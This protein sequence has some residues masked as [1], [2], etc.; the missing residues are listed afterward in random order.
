MI[1]ESWKEIKIA[2][3]RTAW[4]VLPIGGLGLALITG[5]KETGGVGLWLGLLLVLPMLSSFASESL[6]ILFLMEFVWLFALILLVPRLYKL[7]VARRT[8]GTPFN[9]D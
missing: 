7:V 5:F 2:L 8:R 3:K 1:G 9:S 6:V 4:L